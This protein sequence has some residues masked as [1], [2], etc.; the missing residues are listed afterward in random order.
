MEC[1]ILQSLCFV[2]ALRIFFHRNALTKSKICY[3]EKKH[4]E[5]RNYEL[6]EFDVVCFIDVILTTSFN[7]FI[8]LRDYDG[9]DYQ[10]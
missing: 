8:S 6:I 3:F 4:S 10:F 2:G 1:L 7:F 9:V 5:N